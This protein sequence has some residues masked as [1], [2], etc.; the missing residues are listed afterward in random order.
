MIAIYIL[1]V[2]LVLCSAFFSSFWVVEQNPVTGMSTLVD[3]VDQR[4]YEV[5]DG[6]IATN[7]R[8]AS[9]ILSIRIGCVG[10]SW[11]APGYFIAHDNVSY[12]I[13]TPYE[14]IFGHPPVP[15]GM[16][17]VAVAEKLLGVRG[18]YRESV[19]PTVYVQ[20]MTI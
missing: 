9:G 19:Q 13:G 7:E 2:L 16:A 17:L 1:M 3:T 14:H 18:C 4:S 8:W 15:S 6:Q 12:R 11:V 5:E 20:Q 10:G